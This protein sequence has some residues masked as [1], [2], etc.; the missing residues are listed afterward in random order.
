MAE[1]ITGSMLPAERILGLEIGGRLF[2]RI[3]AGV[4]AAAFAA[5]LI[6]PR[7]SPFYLGIAGLM[8]LA[9]LLRDGVRLGALPWSDPLVASAGVLAVYAAASAAWGAAPRDALELS[10]AFAL[11]IGF[12]TV[13]SGWILRQDGERLSRLGLALLIGFALGLTFLAFEMLTGQAL[14]RLLFN[15]FEW[16]RPDSAKNF[17]VRNGAVTLIHPNTLNRN[18]AAL[19]MLAWPALLAASLWPGARLR[20]VL[21]AF[22]VIGVAV[23]VAMSRHESSKLGLVVALGVFGLHFLSSLWTWRVLKAAWV[24]AVL[25]CAHRPTLQ[26]HLCG[27]GALSHRLHRGPLL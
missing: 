3:N 1:R 4:L 7:A 27:H 17:R 22:F 2:A 18:M 14:K 11:A 23:V 16:A 5:L 12:A 26:W 8:A 24:V 6:A 10:A 25:G 15:V 20:Q 19:S 21:L 13:V 9:L